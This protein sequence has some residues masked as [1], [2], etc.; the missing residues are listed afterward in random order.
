MNKEMMFI[1]FKKNYKLIFK[2]LDKSITINKKIFIY[3]SLISLV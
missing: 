2:V 3:L 1:N